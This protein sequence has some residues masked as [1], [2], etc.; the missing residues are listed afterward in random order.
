MFEE[1]L[2]QIRE[3]GQPSEHGSGRGFFPANASD[4]AT[5]VRDRQHP[6]LQSKKSTTVASA[7]AQSRIRS[8]D[9]SVDVEQTCLLHHCQTALVFAQTAPQF[10]AHL[11]SQILDPES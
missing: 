7:E 1:I 4:G 2:E 6:Q 5:I 3:H 10:A 11:G 9:C 8:H